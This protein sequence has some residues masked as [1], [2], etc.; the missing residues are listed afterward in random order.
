MTFFIV[1]FIIG[2]I[3][4]I[5]IV[6]FLTERGFRMGCLKAI[7]VVIVCLFGVPLAVG[8]AWAFIR[9]IGHAVGVL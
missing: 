1:T 2:G 4:G 5:G 7:G 9:S 8:L 3:I 6:R